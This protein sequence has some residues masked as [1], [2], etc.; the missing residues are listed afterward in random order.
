MHN[1]KLYETTEV[2][3]ETILWRGSEFIFEDIEKTD[4]PFTQ[5]IRFLSFVLSQAYEIEFEKEILSAADHENFQNS[6]IHNDNSTNKLRLSGLNVNYKSENSVE[7]TSED[8]TVFSNLKDR[9]DNR[10]KSAFFIETN[11]FN[12]QNKMIENFFK[13]IQK[14]VLFISNILTG[15]LIRFYNIKKSCNDKILEIFLEK[16]KDLFIR[17]DLYRVIFSIKS[18]LLS[19][20]KHE[21]SAN[22]I[23]LY[24]LKPYYFGTSPYFSQDREFRKILRKKTEEILSSKKEEQKAFSQDQQNFFSKLKQRNSIS[25]ENEADNYTNSNLNTL[26]YDNNNNKNKNNNQIFKIRNSN[27]KWNYT[28][29]DKKTSEL[30]GIK[31]NNYDTEISK[32]VLKIPFDQTLL[33]LRKLNDCN[34]ML[35]RIDLMFTLR[36]SILSEIDNFWLNIPLK[37]KYKSVDADNLLSIFIYLIIKSQMSNLIIDIEIIECFLSKNIKLSR[38]GY[39]FSIFQSSIE[40]IIDNINMEQLDV[41]I[42][43]YN[44]NLVAELTKLKE[45]PF[46]I[47]DFEDN[48]NNENNQ[49]KNKINNLKITNDENIEIQDTFENDKNLSKY[50]SQTKDGSMVIKGSSMNDNNENY[51]TVK[52]IEYSTNLNIEL[53]HK[54]F[55]N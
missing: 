45:N 34:S 50:G 35:K 18:Y 51:L 22:L 23:K 4:H 48:K 10:F 55:E 15:A 19:R 11:K 8:D 40:Y 13:Q 25:K 30:D 1:E 44:N 14:E 20:K 46:A 21:F 3:K 33:Q 38:K 52:N 9:D 49:N 17:N 12:I 5:F 47:L 26:N 54:D 7:E 43:E 24:N 41:N 39:F 28:H 42:K 29:F 27:L 53:I 32:N 36:S 37:M 6:L 31:M 16:I 2:S